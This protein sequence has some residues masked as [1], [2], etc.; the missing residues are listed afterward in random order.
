MPGLVVTFL[1]RLFFYLSNTDLR[2]CRH[3]GQTKGTFGDTADYRKW[4]GLL[5]R[6]EKSTQASLGRYPEDKTGRKR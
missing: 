5:N 4:E 2:P 1:G 3:V 6:K